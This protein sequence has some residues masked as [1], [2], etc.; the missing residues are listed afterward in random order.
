[1]CVEYWLMVI[2]CALHLCVQCRGNCTY[3]DDGLSLCPETTK[4]V[5]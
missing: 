5:M 4:F 1:M 2:I 3:D